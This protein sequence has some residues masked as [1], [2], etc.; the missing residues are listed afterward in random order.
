M[1]KRSENDTSQQV[2]TAEPVS[3]SS[4]K[5]PEEVQPKDAT[6][7]PQSEKKDKTESK[8]DV[9]TKEREEER[10][11]ESITNQ[12]GLELKKAECPENVCLQEVATEKDGSG[13][14]VSTAQ[15][16]ELNKSSDNVW[17]NAMF[18]ILCVTWCLSLISLGF[19]IRFF[20]F[21]LIYLR[22][23]SFI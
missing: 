15:L 6:S 19:L 9:S 22:Y 13:A 10:E 23:L 17:P 12:E 4:E 8:E 20:Y 21:F 5:T 18:N 11:A 2:T 16:E 1:V 7:S 14:D 3:V